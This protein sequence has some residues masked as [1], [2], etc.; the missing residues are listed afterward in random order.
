MTETKG[1]SVAGNAGI[2]S[3]LQSGM[4]TSRLA[5][6]NHIQAISTRRALNTEEAIMQAPSTAPDAPASCLP[7]S[8]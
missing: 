5:S 2:S 8:L 4:L 1:V 7:P 3:V 6:R